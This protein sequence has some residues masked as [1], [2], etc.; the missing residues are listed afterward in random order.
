M[1]NALFLSTHSKRSATFC[2]FQIILSLIISIHALQT[3]CDNSILTITLGSS[4]SIHALQTECDM[5]SLSAIDSMT[6]FLSTHSKRSATVW[7]AWDVED[8]T[9]S[10][11]ALQTECDHCPYYTTNFTLYFYPRT[12]NGVRQ[13]DCVI[14]NIFFTIS[15]HALQTECD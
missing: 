9:I 10:I 15:I 12:P 6:L 2:H 4:I 13:Q 1:F 8:F 14:Y 7:K 11:H 5:V 3:E